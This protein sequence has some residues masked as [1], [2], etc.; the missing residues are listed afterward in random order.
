MMRWKATEKISESR[1]GIFFTKG[2]IARLNEIWVPLVKQGQSIPQIY[3]NNKDELM[4]NEKT[5]Y[6]YVDGSRM[7][8]FIRDANT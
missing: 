7:L 4:C 2:E 8:G 5:L 6:N 3:L 1:S